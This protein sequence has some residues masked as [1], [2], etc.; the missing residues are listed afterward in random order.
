MIVMRFVPLL[1]LRSALTT[2]TFAVAEAL[3]NRPIR[4]LG[5][6]MTCLLILAWTAIFIMM[7]RA[8]IDK[9]ILWPQKQEDRAEGGW[10]AHPEEK[11]ACDTR[12]CS[13]DPPTPNDIARPQATNGTCNGSDLRDSTTDSGFEDGSAH[14]SEHGGD[15]GCD[16]HQPT[17]SQTAAERLVDGVTRGNKGGENS[18]DEMSRYGR[19]VRPREARDMV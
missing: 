5:C 11:R 1:R 10:Q 19:P 7:I 14:A 4:I 9:D 13:T 2:A 12:R 6:V 18:D 3:D 15:A 17:D 8:V 16:H